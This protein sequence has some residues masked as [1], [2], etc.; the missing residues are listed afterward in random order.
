MKQAPRRPK[1]REIQLR[2]H[3]YQL[4][5]TGLEQDHRVDVTLEEVAAD[6]LEPVETTWVR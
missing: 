4:S 5:N 3:S 6:G 2:H 1:P